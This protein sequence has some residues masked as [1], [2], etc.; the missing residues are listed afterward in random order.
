MPSKKN[1]KT[2]GEYLKHEYQGPYCATDIIIRHDDGKKEGV[3][4]IDRKNFPLGLALPGG[5]GERMDLYENAVKEGDEETGLERI[6]LDDPKRPLCVLSGL[7]DDPRAH[8]ASITY[9]AKGYGVLK[10]RE[11]EDAIGAYIYTIPELRELIKKKD[12]WAFDRH[13]EILKIYFEH[14]GEHL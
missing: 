1:Y 7:S 12:V 11:E 5:I 3:V 14:V 6:I 10:P 8:I 13:R 2:F 4:I 9:T